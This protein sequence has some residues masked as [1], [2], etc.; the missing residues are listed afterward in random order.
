MRHARF[1]RTLM[2][3]WHRQEKEIALSLRAKLLAVAT[4][5]PKKRYS[6]LQQLDNVKGYREVRYQK[7]NSLNV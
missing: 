3:A 2:P 6:Y 5:E 1:L 7:A 4:V